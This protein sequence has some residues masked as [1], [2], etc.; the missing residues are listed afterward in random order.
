MKAFLVDDNPIA[1]TMLSNALQDAGYETVVSDNGIE[2]LERIPIERP[3]VIILDVMMPEMNGFETAQRLRERPATA[4]IPILLLTARDQVED[5]IKGFDSG[6]DDY[7][8]KPITPPELIARVR[9]LVRRAA[10]YASTEW[11]ARGR[12]VAFLGVKGGVGTT[13]LAVNTA[14]ALAQQEHDV[15]LVDLHPWSGAVAVQLGL[16]PQASLAT[17]A[18]KSVSG[19]TRN[20]LESCLERHTSGVQVLAAT[21]QQSRQ[22]GQLDR[23]QV[24][25][26]LEHL[27]SMA[28]TTV[29][30]AGN[31]LSS[32]AVEAVKNSHLTVLV[33]ESDALTLT[34]AGH[35]LQQLEQII[36]GGDN[37]LGVVVVN[38]SSPVS[39]V[40][41]EEV[42]K[43]LGH[44][45]LCVFEYEPE[46]C[47]HASKT[48]TPVLLGQ[49]DAGMALQVRKLAKMMQK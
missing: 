7:V 48:R 18:E 22:S 13:T 20:L 23:K 6:A 36:L 24:I 21:H 40:T 17:L 3:D 25:R 1:L 9:S 32:M 43:Q 31:G 46:I 4:R 28:K 34:L 41:P 15:V 44:K 39:P 12:M 5:R 45:V 26:V 11:L 33:T 19:I 29:F 16:A 10:I 14:I 49:P 30:D 38:R 8:I 42:E 37:R 47:F 2:A 27:E 35:L